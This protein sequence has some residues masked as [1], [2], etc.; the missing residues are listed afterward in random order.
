MQYKLEGG[1]YGTAIPQ[2]KDAGDYKVFY[3]M[4]GDANHNSINEQSVDVT[5]G[6][7]MLTVSL[8]E[9][10]VKLDSN[11]NIFVIAWFK[12]CECSTIRRFSS[13]AL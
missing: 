9:S 3:K 10:V 13:S 7:A 11:F 8:K 5:I 4:E 12:F 6:K 2:A 1:T